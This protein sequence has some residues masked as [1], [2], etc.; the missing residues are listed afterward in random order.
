MLFRSPFTQRYPEQHPPTSS[1]LRHW[2]D[3]IPNPPK[4]SGGNKGKGR[5]RRVRFNA[6]DTVI[7]L[8]DDDSD[9]ENRPPNWVRTQPRGKEQPK[10]VRLPYLGEQDRWYQSQSTNSP[11][12]GHPGPS[13]R[14]REIHTYPNGYLRPSA[15]REGEIISHNSEYLLYKRPRESMGWSTNNNMTQPTGPARTTKSANHSR[16]SNST[17]GNSHITDHVQ[18]QFIP[19]GNQPVG[20]ILSTV[21]GVFHEILYNPQFQWPSNAEI[22]F[23]Q[24]S[25]TVAR[26]GQSQTIQG[27]AYT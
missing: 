17:L 3:Q 5:E 2:A 22:I 11:K 6:E 24:A 23:P 25:L 18:H 13:A 12:Y 7:T 27:R 9:K 8:Y 14:H 4:R 1:G 15:G 16:N 26:N 19:T 20:M 21:K 10:I